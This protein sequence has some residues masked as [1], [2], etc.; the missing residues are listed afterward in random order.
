VAEVVAAPEAVVVAVQK[1]QYPSHRRR[2]KAE[3]MTES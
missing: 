2:N 3:T 1:K